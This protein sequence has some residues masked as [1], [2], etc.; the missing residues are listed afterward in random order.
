[1]TDIRDAHGE[2]AA[3]KRERKQ[4]GRDCM[5]DDP[6]GLEAAGARIERNDR[7]IAAAQRRFDELNNG[8]LGRSWQWV[9]RIVVSLLGGF[10]IAVVLTGPSLDEGSTVV[11]ALVILAMVVWVWRVTRQGI[12]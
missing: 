7:R 12:R 11:A 8:A 3:A 9:I 1:M 5:T 6:D 4:I 2:L 10:G